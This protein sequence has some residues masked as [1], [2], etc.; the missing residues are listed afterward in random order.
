MEP[1]SGPAAAQSR[2]ESAGSQAGREAVRSQ[3]CTGRMAAASERA[4]A[5]YGPYAFDAS[6]SRLREAQR[7]FTKM[8]RG[9][10]FVTDS[11]GQARQ[12][13]ERRRGF[14]DLQ[15]LGKVAARLAPELL[16]QAEHARRTQQHG[17]QLILL[18]A[19][20]KPLFHP[21][22]LVT[23]GKRLR[24]RILVQQ[25]LAGLIPLLARHGK[26]VFDG[27]CRTAAAPREV[28]KACGLKGNLRQRAV[29]CRNRI[30]GRLESSGFV[31]LRQQLFTV[32]GH[33]ELARQH[34]MQGAA[35]LER[36]QGL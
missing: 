2:G 15:A 14:L 3:A 5:Q 10:G 29:G 11:L 23:R 33:L 6:R 22:E 9:L 7:R 27:F 24:P 16:T 8:L 1:T 19:G 32:N 36:T 30:P 25:R 28:E 26:G 20:G 21:F 34:R 12:R 35:L 13:N 18:T 4:V 31:A 17:P